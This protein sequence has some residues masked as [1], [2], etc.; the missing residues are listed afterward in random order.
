MTT[1]ITTE[2]QQQLIARLAK[3]VTDRAGEEVQIRE[4]HAQRL[5]GIQSRYELLR[6]Q[7]L[8][9]F[10]NRHGTRIN[11]FRVSR[12]AVLVKYETAGQKVL[13]EE[14]RFDTREKE[15]HTESI[16]DARNL[17][18]HRREQIQANYKEAEVIPRVELAKF[19]Q[20]I[21][22]CETQIA[23]VD[24]DAQAVMR[25]R[26]PWPENSQPPPGVPESLPKNS[27]FERIAGSLSY[28]GT[29]LYE[30]RQEKV[31]R[32]LE[33]GWPFLI[34][35]FS[36]FAFLVLTLAAFMWSYLPGIT[37]LY[38]L[39][40]SIVLPI[41]FALGTRQ[42][43]RPLAQRHA[44]R[45]VG[46][47]QQAIAEAR[48][49]AAAALR[50]AQA[51]A[52]RQQRQL[53]ERRDDNM[54]AAYAEW[55][56]TDETEKTRHNQVTQQATAEYLRQRSTI[57]ESHEGALLT[58]EQQSPPEIERLEEDFQ[59]QLLQASSSFRAERSAEL[60][61]FQ[62]QWQ[63]L[64]ARWQNGLAEF[65][66]VLGAM[67]EYCNQHFPSWDSVTKRSAQEMS[68]LS[69]DLAALRFGH[70]HFD[71]AAL[72]GQAPSEEFKLPQTVC[73]FPAVLSYPAVPSLLLEADGEG[74]DAAASVLR[75]VM[76][77]MLT[78][79]PPGKVRFTVIDPVGLGQNF[80]AFMH[81]AD[82]DERLVANRIWTESQHITQ[83]LVDLTEHMEKV[84]QKYLRNEFASIQEYNAQAGEVAEPYQVLVIANFPSNFSEEA[85]RRLVSIASSG[86]RCGVYTLISTDRKM[87]LPPNFNLADLEGPA[88]TLQWD[89]TAKAFRWQQTDLSPLPLVMEQPPD[90]DHLT[91]MIRTIGSTA[92]ANAR[93]EVPFGSA[94]P[95]LDRWWTADS[96]AE[97]EVPLGRAGAKKM[98]MM[99]L[100]KG[101]SQHVLI[102]GKTGSGKSTLL[103]ALITNL[104]IH[105]SPHELQFYLID[106]KKGV[107]F[108]AY[109]AQRL[110]HARVI[111]IESER[112]FGMSVLERLDQELRERGDLFRKHT[113]QDLK[114]YRNAN[115]TAVMPRILLVIDEFQEFFTT[116]DKISHNAGLLLDRLVR[117][118]RAFGIHVL[119][120]SQTLAGAY[121]LARSTIGQMA[122]RI[123][124]QC[125]ESD[126]HL[127]LSE[128]NSAARLLNRPGEAIYNDANGLLEGN[129]PF[130]VVW[131]SDHEREGY[132]KQLHQLAEEQG[133]SAGTLTVFEGNEAADPR[134]NR[135]LVQLVQT[136]P[137]A[138]PT[139]PRAWLG[140]A[141]AIKD[142]TEVVFR[143]QAGA[144]MLIVGQQEELSL[145]VVA[146]SF[147]AL[148]AAVPKSD[149][150]PSFYVLDGMRGDAP[151]AG[152]WPKL[153]AE[154]KV[155]GVVAGIRESDKVVQD[156]AAEVDRRMNAGEQSAPP[157]FIFVYD[158]A[159]FRRLK[160]SDDYSFSDDDGGGSIDKQFVTLLREGPAVGIHTIIWSDNCTNVTRWLD[161]QTLRDL[162]Y[163][164]L[165]QM[166]A[167][168]SSQLMDSPAASK[169]G[170][171]LALYHSEEQGFAEK[172]R[173]YGLPTKEWIEFVKNAR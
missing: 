31:A 10:E 131:L 5:A 27:Y 32:F 43:L 151:E 129:H 112:E 132:L 110:P 44:L 24:V 125:S 78:S 90:D 3:L 140:A 115:P 154:L 106:F 29:K 114:G 84:I 22:Q 39:S 49:L 47:F 108:K 126:A 98:Q 81:L 75:N 95:S 64:K 145:G 87:K 63:E 163:R 20:Q 6:N 41:V 70:Y 72:A 124:L 40:A 158:L 30:L 19:K 170:P 101:T 53:A 73:E 152:F 96:R 42:I 80:S 155:P 82:Y 99:R 165:F 139:A 2:E 62:Q 147:I 164:V 83:R 104:A 172:F 77:R 34:F 153:V 150:G 66:A 160:K 134:E 89:E 111:A 9:Q 123:A 46:E 166:S 74:R 100:G 37:W 141:V 105:Y 93:V 11:D 23:A 79:L 61:N 157:K 12:D 138:M 120:G 48:A 144:N 14:V 162:E 127:I 113:V 159:R 86:A 102:A 25:P 60:Q 119:L 133:K 35:I 54:E 148:A 117:Q 91:D 116:D 59:R 107:E 171:H 122:V 97:I 168:D 167:S 149:D 161:R 85:A 94:L 118:G 33:D 7:I 67:N 45:I 13:V 136:P 18:A 88:A 52:D 68:K 92:K 36:L 103:N 109:A 55:E 128:D 137:T 16:E 169:L 21:V 76:L 71:P 65:E 15:Q 156:L 26:A 4:K 121:S 1:A 51:E 8:A 135:Q 173:P 143:R 28:A 146:N 130:Q 58:I 69:P 17:L 56:R 57:E 50:S 142:P 38:A